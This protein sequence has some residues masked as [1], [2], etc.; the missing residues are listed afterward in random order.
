[1]ECQP[2]FAVRHIGQKGVDKADRPR[3]GLLRPR[4]LNVAGQHDLYGLLGGAARVSVGDRLPLQP[5]GQQSRDFDVLD[6]SECSRIL[7]GAG[8]DCA[9]ND[10]DALMAIRV[11]VVVSQQRFR[12]LSE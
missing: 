4:S 3:V 10:A 2:N 6:E 12:Q 1:M 5:L 11:M 8:N 7:F 9:Q